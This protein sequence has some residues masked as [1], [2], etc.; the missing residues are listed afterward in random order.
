[1]YGDTAPTSSASTCLFSVIEAYLLQVVPRIEEL[2]T[3]LAS[4]MLFF[5]MVGQMMPFY[6][7]EVTSATDIMMPGCVNVLLKFFI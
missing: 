5:D 1:M 7:V 2:V 6:K 4:K 3:C